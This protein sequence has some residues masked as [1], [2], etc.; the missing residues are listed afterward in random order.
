MKY[1]S[2]V[3]FTQARFIHRIKGGQLVTERLSASGGHEGNGIATGQ[4]AS[5]NFFWLCC[6]TP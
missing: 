4:D 6:T 2:Y 1:S 3:N 5:H